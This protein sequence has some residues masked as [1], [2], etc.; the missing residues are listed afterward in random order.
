MSYRVIYA[1]SFIDDVRAHIAYLREQH[2]S[3][4]MIEHWHTRLFERIDSLNE[5]PR[6][7]PVDPIQTQTT[8]VETR[9]QNIGDYLVFYHVDDAEKHVNVTAFVHG[10]R[11]RGTTSD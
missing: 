11:R 7:C 5:W 2:V 4:E 3:D 9:K 10:A 1:P 6:S 8:G